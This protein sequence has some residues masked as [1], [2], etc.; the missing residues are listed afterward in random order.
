MTIQQVDQIIGYLL[1]I[2]LPPS[3]SSDQ[4]ISIEEALDVLEKH[5][6]VLRGILITRR[7]DPQMTPE[8][9]AQMLN[10]Q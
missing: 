8:E 3:V 7:A 4:P 1:Q 2:A 10:D 6:E 9:V 5:C